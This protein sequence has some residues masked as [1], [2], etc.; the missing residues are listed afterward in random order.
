MK[1]QKTYLEDLESWIWKTKSVRFYSHERC[2][3]QNKW[4]NI[5]IGMMSAYIIIIN[6]ITNYDINIGGSISSNHVSF[7]TTAFSI[8]ILVFSQLENSNDFK[9]RAEKFHDCSREL[10]K[11]YRKI[12]EL[13]NTNNS[14][15]ELRIQSN[16]LTIQYNRI[17]EKYENHKEIDYL[18]FTSN[19]PNDFQMSCFRR[20]SIKFQYYFNFYFIYHLLILSP[21]FI[22]LI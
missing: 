18:Y 15:E 21:L 8:L 9:L 7:I 3:S 19:Y 13:K 2:L 1:T 22:F 11:I 12:K 17:L 20:A 14:E 6:L 10:A 4:S 16:K 5:S